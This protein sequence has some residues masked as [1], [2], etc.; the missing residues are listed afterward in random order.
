MWLDKTM[1]KIMKETAEE[2]GFEETKPIRELF[3][4]YF[5][6]I[7][8]L[9]QSNHFPYIKIPKFGYFIPREDKLRK[10]K[11][12]YD[13]KEGEYFKDASEKIGK[14]IERIGNEKNRRKRNGKNANDKSGK[15]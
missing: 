10:L 15:N 2:F 14:A 8:S 3:E 5:R 1:R 13:K 7:R 11:V 6:Y 4:E 9:F 12:R